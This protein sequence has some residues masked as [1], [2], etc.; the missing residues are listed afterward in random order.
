M[1]KR[2]MSYMYA[3]AK[4]AIYGILEASLLFWAEHSKRI[5]EMGY[6]INK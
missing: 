2:G 5:E 1:D 3:E 6:Q 4:K